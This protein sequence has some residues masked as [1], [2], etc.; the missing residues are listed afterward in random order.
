MDQWFAVDEGDGNIE[1]KIV[2]NPDDVQY[3][4]QKSTW[5]CRVQTGELRAAG[6]NAKVLIF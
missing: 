3:M 4:E 6:T 5:L 1:R 2:F